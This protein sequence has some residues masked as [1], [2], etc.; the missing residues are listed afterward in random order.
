MSN[1]REPN[2]DDLSREVFQLREKMEALLPVYAASLRR[3]CQVPLE[4]ERR[5]RAA[6]VQTLLEKTKGNYQKLLAQY[7]MLGLM[8]DMISAAMAKVIRQPLTAP[9]QF[10]ASA[11]VLIA[12]WPS[13]EIKPVLKD[14]S[15]AAEGA[16]LVSFE[17]FERVVLKLNQDVLNGKSVPRGEDEIPRQLY[18]HFSL[19]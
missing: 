16:I 11:L 14:D 15:L 17:K 18:H 7:G 10:S 6:W 19:K 12:I 2:L 9:G 5:Y 3:L 8:G 4:F 13:G 1:Q